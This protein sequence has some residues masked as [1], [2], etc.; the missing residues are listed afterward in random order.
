MFGAAFPSSEWA[1]S[2]LWGFFGA[3][4]VSVG[5]NG[6]KINQLIREK[7]AARVKGGSKG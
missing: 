6:G 7:W 3:G 4:G 2:A 1:S 5:D